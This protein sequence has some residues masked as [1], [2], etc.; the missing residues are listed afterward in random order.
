MAGDNTY[1]QLGRPSP[2]AD[3]N[4]DPVFK[5]VESLESVEEIAVGQDH[6]VAR[7]ADGAVSL[8]CF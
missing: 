6:C 2:S 1:G 8:G 4:I 3:V 7:L 5:E